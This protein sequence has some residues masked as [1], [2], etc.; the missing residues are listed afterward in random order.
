MAKTLAKVAM[1]AALMGIAASTIGAP[2]ALAAEPV[3]A[4]IT[5]HVLDEVHVPASGLADAER[6]AAEVYKRIGIRV[7]WADGSARLAAPDGTRHFDVVIANQRT[8]DHYAPS[9]MTFGLASSVTKRALIFYDRTLAHAKETT[10]DPARVLALV[11]AHEVGHMLLPEYSHA[12]DGLMRATW[13]GTIRRIPGFSKP[14]AAQLRTALV[15][16][17]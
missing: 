17:D 4:T 14:Q 11:L 8:T 15:S 5:L 9:P 1:V 3:G 10:S 13:R 16:T 12:P 6:S 2:A 7:I